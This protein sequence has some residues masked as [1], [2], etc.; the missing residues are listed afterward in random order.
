MLDPAK[1]EEKAALLE[2]MEQ[3][4]FS[5]EGLSYCYP[6]ERVL[7]SLRDYTKGTLVTLFYAWYYSEIQQPD[8]MLPAVAKD[9]PELVQLI[10]EI[11]KN[12]AHSGKM[13]FDDKRLDFTKEHIDH[14]ANT[15][16][17]AMHR[18]GAL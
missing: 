3:Y 12:R 4:G 2:E 16:L 17:D 10:D 9:C 5:T 6:K 7:A 18:C 11:H 8:N 15:L 1:P 13:S 14:A